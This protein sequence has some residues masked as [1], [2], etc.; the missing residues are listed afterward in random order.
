MSRDANENLTTPRLAMPPQTHTTDGQPRLV[1]VEIELGGLTLE[2]TAILLIDHLGGE[3]SAS[4]DYEA[5]IRGDSAG[6]WRVELDFE[7]LK[8][9][10][11]RERGREAA[12][13][14]LESLV[15]DGVEQMLKLVAEPV[16]PVEIVSP[17]LP[18]ERLKDFQALIVRLREAGAQGT[19]ENPIYAFG[20]HLN[21]QP[22]ALDTR[23]L[24]A[25]FK[26]FLCL[27]D[28]LRKRAKIDITRRLTLFAEPFAKDYV[29]QVIAP[30]YWP[31]QAAF[32]EDY[33]SA[34]P[35][36]NRELDMLPLFAH[37]DDDRVRERVSDT[38]VQARPTFHYRLPNCEIDQPDWS[39]H[40]A[41]NDWVEV[42]RLAAEPKRL[43][44]ICRAYHDRLE[45]PLGGLL[46]PGQDDWAQVAEQWLST[47]RAL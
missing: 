36:R 34:N 42:E 40:H 11:R 44:A 47:N 46:N 45:Q 13:A 25:T 37:L 27:A 14:P 26:A 2:Q 20:L 35:T 22:P 18:F 24:L 17:P 12:E 19:G 9:L 30:D 23:T 6:D 4:G 10:G 21:P 39:L 43:D 3:L 5:T 15:K 28:W 8:E 38:R 1:G 31:D 16:V 29:R 33:L 7:L 32:I 41:W